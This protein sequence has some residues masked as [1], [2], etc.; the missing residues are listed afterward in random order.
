MFFVR[1]L[2]TRPVPPCLSVS[3]F[4][5]LN[6][7]AWVGGGGVGVGVGVSART[8]ACV[9]ACVRACVRARASKVE[10]EEGVLKQRKK[11][12]QNKHSNKLTTTTR[13]ILVS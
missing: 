11:P 9:L 2:P 1:S 12:S 4:V 8:R 10:E 3:V 5:Y 6:F 7:G 13:T